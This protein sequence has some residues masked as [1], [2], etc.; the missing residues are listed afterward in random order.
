MRQF[1]L[2]NGNIY[3]LSQVSQLTFI[4]GNYKYNKVAYNYACNK[5]PI[6]FCVR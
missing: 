6:C 1:L 2:K 3:L 4:L 5:S